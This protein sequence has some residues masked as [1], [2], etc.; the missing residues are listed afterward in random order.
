MGNYYVIATCRNSEKN[1]ENAILSLHNQTLRPEYIIVIDD[2]STDKTQS[3]LNDLKKKL[4]I[5][6]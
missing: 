1:I 4:I 5:Y 6:L 2:G 3:I